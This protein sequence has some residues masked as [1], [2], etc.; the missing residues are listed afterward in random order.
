MSEVSGISVIIPCLHDEADL[1]RLLH[2]L[3]LAARIFGRPLQIIV[4]DAARSERCRALCL[5]HGACWSPAA[6]CRGEQLRQGAALAGNDILWFLHADAVLDGQPLPALHRAVSG[7]A[8]GGYFAFRFAGA[9]GWQARLLERGVNWRTRLG[10]PYGDQGLF[11]RRDAYFAAGQHAP[12]PL[13][14]EAPLVHGL[15]ALGE[16]RRLDQG[17][18]ISPRRWQRDGWWRRTLRNR[19]LALGFALGIP[20]RRLARWYAVRTAPAM[21]ESGAHGRQ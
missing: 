19:L 7:G 18:E 5:E 21:G 14:E 16:F 1:Q 4:V 12:W 2:Q 17:L 6:P 10:V 11:A 8:V 3:Q 20:P 15:R 9:A 13:F